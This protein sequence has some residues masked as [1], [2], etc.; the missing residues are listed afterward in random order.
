MRSRDR[1]NSN[2]QWLNMKSYGMPHGLGLGGSMDSFRLFISESFEN[3]T[4][5]ESCLTFDGGNLLPEKKVSSSSN[6]YDGD[7]IAKN[8]FEIDFVEVWA[9]GG[10]QYIQQGLKALAKDREIRDE[11]I[12]RARK[13]DKAQF[14]NNAFDQEFLLS[15]TFSHRAQAADRQDCSTKPTATES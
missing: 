12:Q 2:Y 15:G 7:V 1:S 3:C 9:T 10:E 8:N 11:N 6:D 14:F 13:V 5:G 4:A